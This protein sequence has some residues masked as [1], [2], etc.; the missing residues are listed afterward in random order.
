MR[1]TTTATTRTQAD[2]SNEPGE[3]SISTES[4][5]RRTQD[6][7]HLGAGQVYLD[8]KGSSEFAFRAS[9]GINPWTQWQLT[10]LND[11]SS[12]LQSLHT[13]LDMVI[14]G[15]HIYVIDG[16]TLKYSSG[17]MSSWTTVTGT[18]AVTA[19]SICTDG[20]NVWVAYGASGVYTTTE[21]AAAATQYITSSISSTAVVRFVMGRLMLGTGD[22]I[23]NLTASGALPG[24]PLLTSLYGNMVW[25]D[26]TVGN[27]VI[28]AAGNSGN[29]G[30]VYSIQLTT[31]G[32]ALSPPILAGQLPYG[33]NINCICGYGG[34]GVALGTSLGWRFSEQV[35]ANSFTGTVGLNIGPL[36]TTPYAAPVTAMCAYNRFIWGTWANYDST[37]TGLFRMDLS[38][39]TADLAPAWATD[40][41]ATTQGQVN[42]IAIFGNGTVV[43]SVSGV[44]VFAQTST[45]V[46]HGTIDS[47]LITYGIADSK[48]PVFVDI[49]CQP[50]LGTIQTMTAL[51]GEAFTSC[52]V[53]SAMNVPFFEFNTPQTLAKT[54]ELREV[55]G[56]AASNTETPTL[57]RHTLRS[58]PAPPAP[59]DWNVVIQLRTGIR[60]KD[61]EVPLVP[62][63]EYGFLDSL[64][65]NKVICT[66]QIGN[67]PAFSATIESIDWI[68]EQWD[69]VSGELNGVAVVTC[70]TLSA[71]T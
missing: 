56:S 11:T 38:Q 21:A 45:F 8:R 7:W 71:S 14:C 37:S 59:T 33:E 34:A 46:P 51:D 26:F 65:I 36:T 29:V 3:Q 47:G 13:N 17:S 49:A 4:L 23:Y 60:I 32:T 67:M 24:S 44:G 40:L 43:F 61:V 42:S 41:M 68:P 64:R 70:R 2:T 25:V 58:I 22:T 12:V 50:L 30:V 63:V 1:A 39:F 18:P 55:L 53:A 19:S 15:T 54:I 48:M 20:F 9:K 6:S 16:Q 31:D 35:L 69:S 62:S 27:G 52:G 66:V 5:W 57:T 10:L 28:F